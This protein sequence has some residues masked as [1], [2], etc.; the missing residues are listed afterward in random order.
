MTDPQKKTN[1]KTELTVKDIEE[2]FA[3]LL[4]LN[5]EERL[6]RYAVILQGIEVIIDPCSVSLSV[7]VPP[8]PLCLDYVR[9]E[10][11]NTP[12]LDWIAQACREK[13]EREKT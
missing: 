6:H 13:L 4:K 2:A 5:R 11:N 7:L 12:A 8:S 3:H 10:L 9:V 1:E